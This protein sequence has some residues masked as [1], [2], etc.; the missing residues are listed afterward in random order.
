[1]QTLA[2]LVVLVAVGGVAWASFSRLDTRAAGHRGIRRVMAGSIAITAIAG[3]VLGFAAGA[4]SVIVQGIVVTEVAHAAVAEKLSLGALWRQV[5]PVAWR[6][7]RLLAAAHARGVVA[8]VALVGVAIF[9]LADRS[10]RPRRSCSRSLL[11]L[12]AIPLA[13]WLSTSCCLVPAAI[14]LEHATIR[15]ARSG[16]PGR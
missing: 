9:G 2:Y 7:H 12:A 1:M 4:L 5:K 14:I 16:A 6:L 3:I 13:L 8:R 10:R 15:Q 11:V